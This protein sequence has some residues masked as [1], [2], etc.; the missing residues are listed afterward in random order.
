[1]DGD[2]TVVAGSWEAALERV[3]E[4]LEDCIIRFDNRVARP[5]YVEYALDFMRFDFQP[6][7]APGMRGMEAYAFVSFEPSWRA[8]LGA[9]YRRGDAF[10]HGANIIQRSTAQ[11]ADQAW[12][13]MEV[14]L[15]CE[16]ESDY[17]HV[18]SFDS[19]GRTT[20]GS[21]HELYAMVTE[22][23]ALCKV[24]V[25]NRIMAAHHVEF[26]DNWINFDFHGLRATAYPTYEGYEAYGYAN[27]TRNTRAGLGASYRRGNTGYVA[28]RDRSQYH[29]MSWVGMDVDVYCSDSYSELFEVS[30]RGTMVTGA[31]DDLRSAFIDESRECRLMFDNRISR[32]EYIEYS[33]RT[34]RFDFSNLHAYLNN[35]EAF[36][37]LL[38]NHGYSTQFGSSMRNGNLYSVWNTSVYHGRMLTQRYV[39]LAVRCREPAPYRHVLTMEGS[40]MAQTGSWADFYAAMTDDEHA[41][42]CRLRL[43]ESNRVTQPV[44]MEY[45]T[46]SQPL[47]FDYQSLAAPY[48]YYEAYATAVVGGAMA[49]GMTSSLRRGYAPTV[50][51]R[52]RNQYPL[53]YRV[54]AAEIDFLCR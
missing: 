25:D 24:R 21:W 26:A 35:S 20:A 14:A 54:Q 51:Q 39:D 52:D 7:A 2:G 5:S 46:S 45:G 19:G 4:G 29:E 34:L 15:Y 10:N 43:P 40:G 36:A 48:S 42:E 50:W 53:V 47:L 37:T 28:L 23:A 38:L 33:A 30:S 17:E 44:L 49:T 31:L 3:S 8:G 9:S 32:P 11:Y 13:P 6:L 18:A 16:R 41:Y 27:I 1:M 22:R 12:N